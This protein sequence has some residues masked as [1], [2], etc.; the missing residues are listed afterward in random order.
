M[1]QRCDLVHIEFSSLNNV[2]KVC[3]NALAHLLPLLV[4]LGS[5]FGNVRRCQFLIEALS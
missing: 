4:F 2:R 5:L 1:T 3:F